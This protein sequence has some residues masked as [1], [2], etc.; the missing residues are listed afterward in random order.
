MQSGPRPNHSE[1][2]TVAIHPVLTGPQPVNNWGGH[3][4]GMEGEGKRSLREHQGKAGVLLGREEVDLSGR[5]LR[6]DLIPKPHF[7]IFPG[8]ASK[9]A[10]VGSRRPLDSPLC[11]GKQSCPS[12]QSMRLFGT[13]ACYS[14]AVAEAADEILH[15]W[16]IQ[17]QTRNADMCNDSSMG[18]SQFQAFRRKKFPKRRGRGA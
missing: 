13:A 16:A 5:A 10:G 3:I 18:P 6:Q 14:A 4:M 1:L 11:K 12:H 15:C 7:G 2:H 17:S 8:H 9:M